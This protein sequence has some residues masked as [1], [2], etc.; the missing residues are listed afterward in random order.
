MTPDGLID[1]LDDEDFEDQLG[2]PSQ[3]DD[4]DPES[5][6]KDIARYGIIQVAGTYIQ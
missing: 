6:Y 1:G 5:P 4:N 3:D 2:S